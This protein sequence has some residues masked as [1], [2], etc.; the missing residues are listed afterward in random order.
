VIYAPYRLRVAHKGKAEEVLEI[1]LRNPNILEHGRNQDY[2]ALP[3]AL[4]VKGSLERTERQVLQEVVAVGEIWGLHTTARDEPDANPESNITGPVTIEL[5]AD[6]AAPD[7]EPGLIGGTGTTT[8]GAAFTTPSPPVPFTSPPKLTFPDTGEHQ[9][10]CE[11]QLGK[12]WN[13]QAAGDPAHPAY[14]NGTVAPFE[15]RGGETAQINVTLQGLLTLV[16]KT[17]DPEQDPCQAVLEVY[18]QVGEAMWYP[19]W[20]GQVTHLENGEYVWRSPMFLVPGTYKVRARKMGGWPVPPWTEDVFP[21]VPDIELLRTI[22]VPA[23]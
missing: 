17:I 6:R 11:V 20:L 22:Q 9:G 4:A 8:R 16:V 10:Q 13:W 19:V 2:T 3:I 1:G 15:V 18:R 21:V 23:A 7:G 12:G 14:S 5:W